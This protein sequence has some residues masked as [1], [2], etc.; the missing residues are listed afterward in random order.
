MRVAS[1]G[2][3]DYSIGQMDDINTLRRI[4][5]QNRVIAVVGQ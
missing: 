2:M 3:S 1:L 4:L 5:S